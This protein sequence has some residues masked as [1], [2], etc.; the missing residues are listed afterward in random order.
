MPG[1]V[2]ESCRGPRDPSACEQR[3]DWRKQLEAGGFHY[4][5]LDIEDVFDALSAREAMS[6]SRM[7]LKYNLHRGRSG[8]RPRKYW[9]ARR[10]Y[11]CGPAVRALIEEELGIELKD[12][13]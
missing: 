1:P 5:V 9:V 10:D 7:L 2:S 8:K 11:R 12:E 4:F 6:L 3:D 13:G